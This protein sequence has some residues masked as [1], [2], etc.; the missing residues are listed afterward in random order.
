MSTKT[1]RRRIVL[2]VTALAAV[3]S[4]S[5]L[6]STPANADTFYVPLDT[7]GCILGIPVYYGDIPLCY[8]V[9]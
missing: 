1:L 6:A 7:G 9:D 3:G 2:A 5:V 4:F 8:T